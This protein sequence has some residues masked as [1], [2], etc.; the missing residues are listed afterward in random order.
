MT[1][2]LEQTALE[3][4]A[5][6]GDAG[7]VIAPISPTAHRKPDVFLVDPDV[8]VDGA[9]ALITAVRP[10][11]VFL[12]VDFFDAD[13]FDTDSELVRDAAR[14]HDGKACRVSALWAADGLLYEW[15]TSAD[16]YDR[17]TDDA[18]IAEVS[19]RG[20]DQMEYDLRVQ[21]SAAAARKLSELILASPEFRRAR[22]RQRNP[23]IQIVLDEH[24]D[25]AG[26]LMF[27]EHFKKTVRDQADTEIAKWERQLDSDE[28]LLTDLPRELRGARTIARQKEITAGFVR[29]VADGWTLTDT[30]LERVR[31]DAL[32]L[33]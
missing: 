15:S 4:R 10:R 18:E 32:R 13:E 31:Q 12:P 24:P 8:T 6:L 33:R 5:R 14:T 19:E 16:W 11:F 22:P 23:H 25:L 9:V 30:F 7:V 3:L 20:V 17:L 21:A 27:V 2:D 29:E 28:T 26:D 1:R